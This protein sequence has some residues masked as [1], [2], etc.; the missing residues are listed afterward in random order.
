MCPSKDSI[1][2]GG[3]GDKTD[4]SPRTTR[5][6]RP[7]IRA[8][9][10]S[11]R[12][13]R[14]RRTGRCRFGQR[15]RTGRVHRRGQEHRHRRLEGRGLNDPLPAG[16]G[17][18]VT[19]AVDN[20]TGTPAKFVLSGAKGSQTLGLASS[21]IP[22]GADYIVHITAMT[23]STECG[24]YNNTATLTTTNANNPAPASASGS[25]RSR[26][27]SIVKTPDAAQVS[28][29]DQIGFTMT[30][31]NTGAGRRKGRQP[32]RCS[33][34]QLRSF[35]D[36]RGPGCRLGGTCSIHVGHVELA[37][38]RRF[39]PGRPRPRTRSR[40]TSRRRRRLRRSVSCPGT[41]VVKQH[42]Q[43]HDDERR[44]GPVERFD[45]RRRSAVHIVKTA[46]AAQVSAGDQIGFTLRSRTRARVTRRASASAISCRRTRAS[47]GRLRVRARVG[48]V[49][50]PSPRAR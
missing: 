2:G 1:T 20:S 29:G 19:W 40:F 49:R 18:G 28:A 39:R 8:L 50:A 16:S 24:T 30:V 48:A 22:A 23:S 37:A 33:A 10:S 43:R 38:R 3:S 14:S 26:R 34:D 31:F 6:R 46:D 35:V 42:R 36:G 13:R 15:G 11:F 45:L 12:M 7:E 32:Q 47:R 25:A 21:T 27:S 4:N 17:S 5:G 9:R 41:G 44:L